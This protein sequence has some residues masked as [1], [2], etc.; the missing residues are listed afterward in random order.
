[1]YA[2]LRHYRDHGRLTRQLS[3]PSRP[4][5]LITAM[6]FRTVYDRSAGFKIECRE[7]R[8]GCGTRWAIYTGTA[9]MNA[10]LWSNASLM[11]EDRPLAEVLETAAAATSG[12]SVLVPSFLGLCSRAGMAHK[13][14]PAWTLGRT[15]QLNGRAC[16][17]IEYAS[18]DRSFD[19][20]WID[21]STY[22]L[23][24]VE[25]TMVLDDSQ[26]NAF[27]ACL[28]AEA[29]AL[30]TDN[31]HVQFLHEAV[32]ANAYAGQGLIVGQD[33]IHIF[34]DVE[35]PIDSSDLAFALPSS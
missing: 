21:A 12:I 5:P 23:R 20:Y 28:E 13:P 30:P 18:P 29:T 7:T 19:R 26:R 34:P 14:D 1:M 27:L 10:R 8:G 9:S 17:S 15:K 2:S 35:T 4:S 6:S 31:P 11:D 22:L 24:R 25:R 3:Y 16:H 33:T 32:W